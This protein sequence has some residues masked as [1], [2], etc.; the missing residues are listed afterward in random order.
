MANTPKIVIASVPFTDEDSPLAAPAVL[1][2]KLREQGFECVAL[3]LNIDIFNFLHQ[4]SDRQLF[5]DFFYQQV[6]HESVVDDLVRM[7]EHYAQQI[8]RHKPDILALSLF[9]YDCQCFAAWLCAVMRHRAPGLK[10]VIG[11]P[12]LQTL[13]NSVLKYPDRLRRLG[14]IDDY[15]AGDGELAIVEYVRGNL[16]YPGI[17]S[18][19]WQ[20]VEPFDQ[21][22]LPDFDD[23]EFFRYRQQMIPIIDSRGCVQSC[24][25]CDVIAFWNKFQYL[26]AE[27]IFGQIIHH[28]THRGIRRFQFSS[29]ICNGN[30]KQFRLLMQLIADHND[31]AY[32][33]EQIHWMG[34][35]I[36][37]P[38]NSHNEQL[39][40]NIKKSNGYL[41]CGVESLV[42]SVRKNLG[43]N[44]NNDDLEYHLDM[45]Q[46]YQVPMNL[47]LIASYHTET[48]D[49][50]EYSRQWFRDHKHFANNTVHQVQVTLPAVLPGTRLEKNINAADFASNHGYRRRNAELL[51]ETIAQCGFNVKSFL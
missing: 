7:L 31:R 9:S 22:P 17:N 26:T 1:K 34:S 5:L 20:P 35:F 49:D 36:I 11:G 46:R 45:A 47:L 42:Q 13:Q 18:N 51:I 50:R 32:H 24:E 10:I 15:I 40:H 8:M 43:K 27:N 14:L 23:Y 3:D 21:Q 2:A 44:F 29:S 41:L 6:I 25:F 4:R 33:S 28:V 48:E 39:W 37:R 38:R 19:T 12:G 16:E 30:L